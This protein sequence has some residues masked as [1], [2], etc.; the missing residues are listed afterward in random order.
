MTI[1]GQLEFGGVLLPELLNQLGYG[2]AVAAPPQ[3]LSVPEREVELERLAGII[4]DT[5]NPDIS[6]VLGIS[7]G[8]IPATRLLESDRFDGGISVCGP[9]GSFMLQV[10]YSVQLLAVVDY[11]FS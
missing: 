8:A 11:F 1:A 4:E 2:F 9:I 5:L 3:L 6:Y 7:Q 10:A